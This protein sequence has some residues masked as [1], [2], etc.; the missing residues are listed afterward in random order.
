MTDL[1]SARIF[2][3]LFFGDYYLSSSVEWDVPCLL[4]EPKGKCRPCFDLLMALRVYVCTI[5][6]FVERPGRAVDV[7]WVTVL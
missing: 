3:G 2:L 6:S 5:M 1:H 7:M 4:Q